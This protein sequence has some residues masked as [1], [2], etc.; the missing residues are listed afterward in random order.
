[1][2][3]WTCTSPWQER[4]IPFSPRDGVRGSLVEW[5]QAFTVAS[6]NEL[7]TFPPPTPELSMEPHGELSCYL[8][9]AVIRSPHRCGCQWKLSGKHETFPFIWEMRQ[10]PHFSC[11]SKARKRQE[12]KVQYNPESHHIIWKFPGCTW[13]SFIIPKINQKRSEVEWEK[14]NI[15]ITGMT[16]LTDNL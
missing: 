11:W 15:S 1:M 7:S 9:P 8:Y 4:A 13:K 5:S 3:A 14:D 2:G 6:I 12:Q 16:E 10:C